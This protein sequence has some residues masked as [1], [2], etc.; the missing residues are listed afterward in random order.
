MSA[1]QDLSEAWAGHTGLE[2][3]TFLKQQIGSAIAAAGGK[4]GFVEMVGTDLKFYDSEGGTVIATISLGGDV[5]NISIDTS[6]GQVF[7]I[8]ADET[9]KIVT[10]TPSTRVSAFGS[11]ESEP[12]PEGYSYVVAVNTGGGYINRIT[13]EINVGESGSFDIRPF[14]ATGD[15]YIR[16][17]V[18]GLT[19][20]QT[21]TVVLTGTLTTL[22]MSV[23][24]AWQNVWHEKESY[25][26]TGIRFAGSLIKYLHVA[27]DDVEFDPVPYSAGQSYTT[28]ATT[29]TIPA[30][31]FPASSGNGIHKVTLWMAA[32]GISTPVSTFYIMCAAEDDTTPMVAINNITPMAVNFTSDNIFGYAVYNANEV[33]FG[34]SAVLGSTTYPV[35]SGISIT[36]RAEGEKYTFAYPLEI[37][38]GSNTVTLGTLTAVATPYSGST[39]GSSH[40]VTTALDNTYSYIATPG[41]LFY[42]NA[43]TRDNGQA[44][45]QTII[46]EM[47][48]SQDGNFAAQYSAT[49]NG[50]S[51]GN[52]GWIEEQIPTVGGGTATARA[53]SV[54]AGSSVTFNGFAPLFH[55]AS[56]SGF[57]LEMLLKCGHPSDYDEPVFSAFGG[58]AGL[59]IYPTKIVVF[60][61]TESDEVYQS[62]NLSENQITHLTITFTKNY[63]GVNGRN[64]VSI[65]VNG[66]SNVNFAF[67]GTFGNGD[68]TIG[69]Q[70]TDAYLYKMRV[71]GSALEPQAVFNNFLNAIIDNVE[72]NRR[73]TYEKNTILDGDV[74]DYTACKAAGYNI[75]VV[76]M[77]SD[78]HQIPSV[79]ND[80][81][82]TGCSLKFEYGQHPEW[83]VN[84]VNVDL[85]G[86]GTTSKRYF[87]W[88]LRAKTNKNTMW[89]YADGSAEKGKEGYFAGTDYIRVDRITAKK[90]YASSMQGHKMGFTGIY[91]DLFKAVGLSSHLPNEDYRVAVYEFP[92]VGFRH[93]KSN[94][95]YEFM[96]LY[97]TG[98]DKGSKVTFGYSSSYGSL[99]SIEGPNHAP[100]GT[101][102][103]HPWVDVTYDYQ[104]ET[105]RFGGEEGWDCD[106][107]GGGL[108][109]GEQSDAAA[110]LALYTSEW[111]PAYDIVYH[112]SPYIAS[113]AETGYASAAAINNDLTAFLGGST[114]GIS[115]QLLNFYDTNYDLWFYRTSTGQ[116]ENLTTV[117]GN[118]SHNVK[119]YL[120]LAGTP[121][122]AQIKAARAAKFKSEMTNYW[123][124]DQTLFHYCYCIIFGVTD[125]FAK[126]SYPFKFEALAS[127]N[128]GNRWGW[129]ED[130]LDT[131]LMTDNNG[132]NTKSYSVEHGD[133]NDGVQI[134]QG[135]NSA[136]W[137]LIR[138]NYQT[139]IR[140]MMLRIVQAA[141]SIAI[142]LGIQGDGLHNSLFNLTSYYC[143]E[144]SSRYFSATLYE[145]DKRWSYL[146]PWLINPEA[147]YNGVKPLTQALGDQYQAEKLWMER[148]IAYIFSKYR[149]GAFAGDNIGYN[150]FVFTLAQPFTF[151]VT[152]AIDLYPVVSLANSGDRQGT[153]TPAGNTVAITMD[154]A[155]GQTRNYFH[156]GDWIASLGDLSGMRLAAVGASSNIDFSIVGS[157]I[158]DLKVGAASGVTFNATSLSVKSPTI[159]S[160]DARNTTTVGNSVDL[161][162]CPRLRSV[163]FEGSGATG[164]LL[165]VGAKLTEVSFPENATR[166]FMHSLPFLTEENLTLPNLAGISSLYVNNCPAIN[167]LDLVRDILNT[168]GN[169]LQYVTLSWRDT[170]VA[171]TAEINA[172]F[173]LADKA[174]Y[175]DY[176]TG[177]SPTDTNGDPILEGPISSNEEMSSVIY[178]RIEDT[179]PR[180]Q[181]DFDLTKVYIDFADPAVE[182]IALANWDTIT[183]DDRITLDEARNV[184]TVGTLFRA[185]TNITSFDELRFFENITN[186]QNSN[187]TNNAAFYNCTNLES[188]TLPKTITALGGYVFNN[189]TS[190]KTIGGTE[191]IETLGYSSYGIT[192]MGCTSLEEINFPN[193]KTFNGTQQF[194]NCTGLKRVISLGSVTQISGG[195]N[196]GC[197]MG[198]T[199]LEEVNLPSTVT[200]IQPYAF[201]G[202]IM[203]TN[204]GA[205]PNLITIGENAFYQTGIEELNLSNVTYIGNS[206][207]RY[208]GIKEIDCPK[209]QTLGDLAF[210]N[211]ESLTT[212]KDL[213]NI[214]IINGATNWG[215]FRQ[216]TALRSVNLPNTL[217][218]IGSQAFINCTGINTTVTFPESL[219]TI[220]SE[221]FSNCPSA[222][223]TNFENIT[224]I[225]SNAFNYAFSANS[226]A[227]IY[228]RDI[229]SLAAAAFRDTGIKKVTIG[230][231]LISIPGYG[232]AG[233]FRYQSRTDVQNTLEEVVIEGNAIR[234]IGTECFMFRSALTKINLPTS[235]AIIGNNAFNSTSI[236]NTINL[237]N[238]TSLG[239]DAFAGTKI[240]KVENLGNIPT[241]YDTF[242]NCSE[243][244]EVVVPSTVTSVSGGGYTFTNC[245][246]LKKIIFQ[247]AAVPTNSN[248]FLFNNT[249]L[250]HIEVVPSL[251]PQYYKAT[252]WVSDSYFTL[253]IG[254]NEPN[255]IVSGVSFRR[256]SNS[257]QTYA[258]ADYAVTFCIEVDPYHTLTFSGG[259]VY[260]GTDGHEIMI[261]L[262]ENYKYVGYYNTTSNPKTVNINNAN[263]KYI[264]LTIKNS[265]LGNCYVHDD[266]DNVYL[267]RGDEVDTVYGGGQIV[268]TWEYDE[269]Y[270]SGKAH[271]G[272]GEQNVGGYGISEYTEVV[273][274]HTLEFKSGYARNNF[275][276]VFYDVNQTAQSYQN[277]TGN[278]MTCT[279]P[280]GAKYVS[281]TVYLAGMTNHQESITDTTTGFQLWP[282]KKIQ[283]VDE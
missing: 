5:Y 162:E 281:A 73:A 131:V 161:M 279:V 187:G 69:Q 134:F 20:G 23:N 159:T 184:T 113:I 229:T 68:F 245:T 270:T 72:Y 234:E 50:F 43:A 205:P 84:V 172:M 148:R 77:D 188:V 36:D 271:A 170:L 197:F 150:A 198:C 17:A 28:T 110:I 235:I 239:S 185:N 189:C 237:P 76:E 33:R 256:V 228:L 93:I 55:V 174:G 225:G 262:S 40:T 171:T 88:N 143:W 1:I 57:T 263:V 190:L 158:Q 29:Y 137:V 254:G 130:D 222:T 155:D 149:I 275:S 82:Y 136:L 233:C 203:L 3:E 38:T 218:T 54:P 272:T 118:N 120:G 62:V 208:S 167:P 246:K 112:C 89:Y 45:Y 145:K 160:I 193:L 224:S 163:L 10:I 258:N 26:I 168:T 64:L 6:T 124:L 241:L 74:V 27:L 153:R 230:P 192:F 61:S 240:V 44:N 7:Y 207:F 108:S 127:S 37:D 273:E 196:V 255:S 34:L 52:D 30:S 202:C 122:T 116:F 199:A 236:T 119:T 115:N 259:F 9:E 123:D 253:P 278:S 111:K 177:G 16:I 210:G 227:E 238:L 179:F 209:L 92:F 24:H 243:L 46:N 268:E 35:A 42:L 214:T 217:Q 152:P 78:S 195:N 94:D 232:N 223:F 99:L 39:S 282:T 32:Q 147:T 176:Q 169:N 102:F 221:A 141:E 12:F 182:A 31:A 66:I 106:G 201:Y 247:C 244:Q 178:A 249:P 265:E 183:D 164:L 154:L 80:T 48:A 133:L 95:T 146:E 100:R 250:L 231:N 212:I 283:V 25:T 200:T 215:T 86:Q 166:V 248:N 252:N 186:L 58:G 4:V 83:D 216:C 204:V 8:L 67:S 129:R 18:T 257:T 165:P 47:G 175:V 117:E 126:N 11:Q 266:T 274:G 261:W 280:S 90:N 156:G 144:Q 70:D 132:R 96:G 191:Y 60:S 151:N 142:S 220:D 79:T 71:Y 181:L 51:W 206:A 135:G 53:L 14:L 98:P 269:H 251:L 101:R 213:G 49:W 125:N 81:V 267:W 65:F 15:N 173:A 13:G 2:V 97:T 21:K 103:L 19:S 104:D 91:N 63:E 105:L 226:E 139:E 219:R 107:I 121:T 41:A 22:T 87:R 260:D 56:Y 75:M 59:K 180:V 157:R 277:W 264:R 242:Y 140:D 85:D 276:I 194:R 114:N 128:T 211:C 109:S 138:D